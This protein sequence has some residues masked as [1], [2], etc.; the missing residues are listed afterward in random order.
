[1]SV[2][3]SPS[4]DGGSKPKDAMIAAEDRM[5]DDESHVIE[6]ALNLNVDAG[7]PSLRVTLRNSAA[8]PK[9]QVGPRTPPGPEPSSVSFISSIFFF[10]FFI[11]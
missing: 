4:S 5:D 9:V 7:K 6:S 3:R 1:V 2:E 11:S 10:L 8:S